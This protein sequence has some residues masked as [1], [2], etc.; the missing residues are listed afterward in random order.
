MMFGLGSATIMQ[1][2]T[3]GD[4]SIIGTNALVTK[5]VPPYTVVGGNPA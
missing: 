3:V 2:I 5:D 4:G 1:G